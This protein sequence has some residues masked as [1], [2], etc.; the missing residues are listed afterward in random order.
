MEQ[1]LSEGWKT[2]QED[3]LDKG[4]PDTS[5]LRTLVEVA[6]YGGAGWAMAIIQEASEDPKIINELVLEIEKHME[7]VMH[8]RD[9]R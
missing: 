9:Q 8:R 4:W 3:V 6:F 7:N 1:R 2:F 5:A